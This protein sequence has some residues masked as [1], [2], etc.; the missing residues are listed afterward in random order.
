M[1]SL[2]TRVMIA[3]NW[4]LRQSVHILESGHLFITLIEQP[5]VK[6]INLP[7][8]TKDHGQPKS[9]TTVFIEGAKFLPV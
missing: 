4:T 1:L 3:H 9:G 8:V 2:I 7:E 5:I 6:P